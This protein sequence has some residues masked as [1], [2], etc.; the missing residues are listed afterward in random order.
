[1]EILLA[2]TSSWIAWLGAGGAQGHKD[3]ENL[4]DFF[5]LVLHLL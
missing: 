5:S 3:C 2:G 4:S 1:M